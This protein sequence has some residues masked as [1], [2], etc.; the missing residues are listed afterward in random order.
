MTP[1]EDLKEEEIVETGDALIENVAFD[2]SSY[3]F[4]IQNL[5]PVDPNLLQSFTGYESP[6]SSPSTKSTK[7]VVTQELVHWPLLMLNLFAQH[8]STSGFISKRSVPSST[9]GSVSLADILTRSTSLRRV[10]VERSPGG[11]PLRTPLSPKDPVTSQDLIALALKK[12]FRQMNKMSP[13]PDTCGKSPMNNSWEEDK[14]NLA[15]VVIDKD[16]R[17][18]HL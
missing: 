11:T 14:E 6:T 15:N 9:S 1:K 8:S 17:V 7:P 3:S 4:D 12:K 18:L 16:N 13:S 10:N 5:P 2:I